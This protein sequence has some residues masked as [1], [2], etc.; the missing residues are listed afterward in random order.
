[1]KNYLVILFTLFIFTNNCLAQNNSTK[2]KKEILVSINPNLEVFAIVE[3]YANQYSKYLKN[4][5]EL[6]NSQESTRPL[7]FYAY[8][9][10]KNCDNIAIAKQMAKVIDT[11]ISSKVGGQDQ[12]FYALSYSKKFPEKGNQVPFKFYNSSLSNET[13]IY[14]D[15]QIALLIEE[16]R[17]YYIK[18]KVELFIKKYKYFYDGVLKEVT[19]G[20]SENLL[21]SLENY[22]R[23]K[24]NNKYSVYVIPTRALSIGEYQANACK[25]PL[26]NNIVNNIQFLSSSYL[27]VKVSSDGIY[28]KFGFADNEYL[29][30]MI[31]HEFGHTFC[32]FSEYLKLKLKKTEFLFSGKWEKQMKPFGYLTWNDCINEHIVRT[33]EI[34]IAETKKNYKTAER[35]RKSY[36]NKKKFVLIP[37]FEQKF[38][39]YE[40]KKYKYKSFQDFLPE[41][42]TTLDSITILKRDALLTKTEY[43]GKKII[44]GYK[45]TANDIT[46]EFD[47][48]INFEPKTVKSV[49]I[50][51]GFNNWNPK[52]EDYKL[53]FVSN[54]KYVL[55]IPKNKFE[56]SKVYE[57]KFVINEAYWQDVPEFAKNIDKNG[58]GNL[59]LEID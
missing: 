13:N 59:T 44:Y 5:A 36:I 30:D 39:E 19:D 16:L 7:A 15:N 20:I 50:A 41:I 35:L 21:Y 42:L 53:A 54:K 4:R 56:K 6:L 24:S 40:Q 51:G 9:N 55:I 38:M 37:I 32:E 25:V 1:M 27:D 46:F 18:N 48:P 12:I 49:T 17:L 8:Q 10:F 22:Y 43:Q 45:Q 57:F 2:K 28:N 11:I 47:L 34:R 33:G 3:R 58:S 52:S 29:Q 31:V 14:I 23:T 26:K